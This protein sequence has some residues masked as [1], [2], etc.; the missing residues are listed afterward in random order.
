MKIL[1]VDDDQTLNKTL[2]RYLETQGYEV[3]SAGDALQALDAVEREPVDLIIADA[4]M[5]VLDGLAFLDLLK[6]DP[7]RKNLPVILITAHPDDKKADLSLRKGAAFFLPKPVDFDR[8][9][10]LVKFAE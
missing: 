10:A 7:S 8:L 1:V 6:A 2:S 5:P 3:R 4:T 9:L